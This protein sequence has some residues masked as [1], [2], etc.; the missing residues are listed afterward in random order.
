MSAPLAM[1][2]LLEVRD[3][4]RHFAGLD[5]QLTMSALRWRRV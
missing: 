1:N 5:S 4:T 2:A 3:V